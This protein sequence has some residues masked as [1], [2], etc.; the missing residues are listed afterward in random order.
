MDTSIAEER[1]RRTARWEEKHGKKLNE[2]S[3]NE[4][5]EAMMEIGAMTR[6]EA[7]DYLN[8]LIMNR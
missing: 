3:R 7:E 6:Q 2:L 5:I 1:A 4:W 8:Y